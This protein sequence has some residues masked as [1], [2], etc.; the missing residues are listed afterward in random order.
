VA[1]PPA[2]LAAHTVSSDSI[3]EYPVTGIVS[4]E[5]D[6]IWSVKI[7]AGI[8]GQAFAKTRCLFSRSRGP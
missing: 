3:Q 7:N 5:L 4:R 6:D 2:V 1:W 8:S